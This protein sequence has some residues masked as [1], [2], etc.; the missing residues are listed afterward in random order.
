MVLIEGQKG[1]N[2][3]CIAENV[4]YIHDENGK[5]TDEINKIYQREGF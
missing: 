1:A 5:Y 3:G 2:L 4:L